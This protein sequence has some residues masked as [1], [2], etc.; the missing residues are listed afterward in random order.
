MSRKNI[1]KDLLL[2]AILIFVF[3]LYYRLFLGPVRR[4]IR[5]YDRELSSR[6]KSAD[7]VWKRDDL[8][9][10]S[11]ELKTRFQEIKAGLPEDLDSYDIIVMLSESDPGHL[12]KESL[13]FL[14][15][16]K[17]KDCIVL[18]VRFHFSTDYSGLTQLLSS[19]DSL[20]IR[21]FVSDMRISLIHPEED[22][23]DSIG[24]DEENTSLDV[25]M[26]LNFYKKGDKTSSDD[27]K[28]GLIK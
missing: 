8:A 7:M 24:T 3:F 28:S 6:N 20:S 25:E 21:P 10:R 27:S 18:P 12:K 19:L 13:I 16:V 11:L 23:G 15:P 9:G 4:D 26:T 17:K 1:R 22:N 5:N 14:E 2:P